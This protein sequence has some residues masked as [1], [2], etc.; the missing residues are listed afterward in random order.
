MI[1][2]LALLASLAPAAALAAPYN[3]SAANALGDATSSPTAGEG[4]SQS[5]YLLGDMGGLREL[6]SRAGMDLSIVETS[7]IFGNATGGLRT[8]AD[9]DGVTTADL[10]LETERAFGF[11]GGTFNVS[12]LQIHGRNLSTDD[13]ATLQTASGIE[14]ERATRL[15]ELWYQQKFLQDDALDIKIGQQSLDNEFMVSPNS[16]NFVN[17]MMGWPMLPS[18]DMPSGGPAYPMASPGIRLRYKVTPAVTVLGG[19]FTANPGGDHAVDAQSANPSGVLF[20]LPGRTLVIGEV[21]YAYP[22]LG[23]MVYAG[24]NEPLAHVYRLGAWHEGDTTGIYGVADQMLWRDNDDADRTVE[25]FARVMGTPNGN[26]NPVQFSANFGV[27]MHEPLLHRDDDTLSIGG[28][29]TKTT[30]SVIAAAET[31]PQQTGFGNPLN[32]VRGDETF[33][34]LNYSVSVTQWLN[35]IPDFQYVFFPGSGVE[36]PSAPGR[37]IANE[38]VFGLRTNILF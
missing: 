9:Y 27:V 2:R 23:S 28:G 19:A 18:A 1:R 24:E 12:A 34:E 31:I 32:L 36:N 6:L 37:R 3:P 26:N 30:P 33:V 38:A 13:L 17:T 4:L 8:G 29:F 25:A 15:W 14:A 22:S 35:V 7:E 16:L 5:Q 20:P 21:Q 11:H 10:T